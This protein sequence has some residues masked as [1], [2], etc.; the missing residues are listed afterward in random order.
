MDNFKIS[1]YALKCF[2]S[3]SWYIE[4]EKQKAIDVVSKALTLT[5]SEGDK[6]ALYT[7]RW[8]I[9][10]TWGS[11]EVNQGECMELVEEL[12]GEY[13]TH[14]DHD[15]I[16]ND[17]V[18]VDPEE[19]DLKNHTPEIKNPTIKGGIKVGLAIGH[20]KYTGA[21]SYKGDDEWTT[22]REVT[23]EAQKT[24]LENGVD[25][26][27]FIRDKSLGYTAAMKKHGRDM[28]E[29]GSS[30]NVEL[31]FN[32]A[33]SSSATGTE[34]I[35]S[36]KKSGEYFKPLCKYFTDIFDLPL[37]G[38][39]GIQLRPTGRGSG[40]CRYTPNRSGVWE[41][42][43]ANNKSEWAKFDGNY[44]KEGESFAFGLLECLEN[45]YR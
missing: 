40:F 1:L 24:L 11:N 19:E 39:K 25:T 35:V 7:L 31:H 13:E 41:P 29:F 38:D 33:D 27:I 6:T 3:V 16:P 20:N 4:D 2:I 21:S 5:D 15:R 30:V 8:Y 14:I 44:K 18:V 26:K 23:L 36:T 43:F 22:R 42:C 28:K 37:R 45:D 10:N 12:L 32:S 34:M 9:T 17:D